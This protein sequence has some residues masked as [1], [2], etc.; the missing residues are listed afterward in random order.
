MQLIDFI[1]LQSKRY[2]LVKFA[3]IPFLLVLAGCAHSLDYLAQKP[4]EAEFTSSKPARQVADCY[5]QQVYSPMELMEPEPGHFIIPLANG[6][7]AQMGRWDFWDTEA[8]SRIEL[9]SN[10]AFGEGEDKMKGCL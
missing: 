2:P 9:R 3:G 5:R 4:V 10:L 6:Y 1:G 8:G 7:G